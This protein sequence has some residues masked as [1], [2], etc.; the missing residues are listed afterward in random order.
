MMQIHPELFS[1]CDD[2]ALKQRY[3]RIVCAAVTQKYGQ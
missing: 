3:S 1:E 2:P